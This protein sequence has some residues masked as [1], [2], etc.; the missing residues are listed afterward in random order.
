[1]DAGPKVRRVNEHFLGTTDGVMA[2][3]DDLMDEIGSVDR[4]KEQD[5]DHHIIASAIFRMDITEVYFAERVDDVAQRHRLTPGSSLDLISDWDCTKKDHRRAAWK[6]IKAEDPYLI[7]GSPPCTLFSLLQQ[8]HFSNNKNKEG[9][10]DE[11][12]RRNVDA[13]EHIE[14]CC[15]MYAY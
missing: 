3:V 5:I 8:I 4:A 13:I 10:M 12:N 6:T 11:F 14:V 2:P 9:W 15:M 1:M 7:I